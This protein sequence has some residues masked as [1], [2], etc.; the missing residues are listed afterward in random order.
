MLCG[1]GAID[2]GVRRWSEGRCVDVERGRIAVA[3]LRMFVRRPHLN[4]K[5]IRMSVTYVC[6]S[7]MFNEEVT[8]HLSLEREAIVR[9][10]ENAITRRRG[11]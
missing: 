4:K 11:R 2:D 8:V 9:T 6:N 7:I 5:V 1:K 3:D 10:T